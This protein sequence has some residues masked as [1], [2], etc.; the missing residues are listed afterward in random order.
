MTSSQ[1]NIKQILIA[2]VYITI[3]ISIIFLIMVTFFPRQPE[4]IVEEAPKPQSIKVLRYGEIPLG[5]GYSDFWA[6]I[7]NP[8][9]DFGAKKVDY[10]FELKSTTGDL[11]N[12]SGS[13]YILPGDRKRYVL[14]LNYESA[15]SLENFTLSAEPV[16][17]QL[18]R[19]RLPELVVRNV[20]LGVSSKA[21]NPF[22]LFG[23]LTN[24]SDLNLKNVQII[25]ILTDGNNNI[26]GVNETLVRDI[27]T[28]ESRDFEMTW[29]YDIPNATV[30]D[31]IIYP[32]VNVLD[33]MEL[34]L[35]LQNKPIFD[36]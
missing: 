23:V 9:D 31:T 13:T 19:F 22:T 11:V 24:G 20:N 25:G 17:T 16:W 12:K 18:S 30:A 15:Y 6:E 2:I 14:L 35:Q 4:I 26:I 32:Q 29:D 28:S 8:N 1:R 34:L 21:G 36:R 10:I 33:N 7:S 5:N 3:F 27:L